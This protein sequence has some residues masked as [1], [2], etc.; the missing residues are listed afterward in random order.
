[1]TEKHSYSAR[2][3]DQLIPQL[4]A[5][6]DHIH[7]CKARA[8]TLAAEALTSGRSN[9]PEDVVQ[10]QLVRSQVDFL[11]EAVQDD[12]NHIQAM[13]G[14]TKDLDMGLVDFPGEVDGRDVWLCWKK[15]EPRVRYWHSLDEGY[16]E[17]QA[18]PHL[19][20]NTTLH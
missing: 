4:E 3:I 19:R 7:G 20:D 9:K 11:M 18:L 17:R 12:I 15:G 8:E 13:G 6:F 5:I 1:M 2:E 10:T 14:F 16:R